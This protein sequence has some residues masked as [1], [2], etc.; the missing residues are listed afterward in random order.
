MDLE[1]IFLEEDDRVEPYEIDKI[2]QK[3]YIDLITMLAG[4]K[5]KGILDYEY[6]MPDQNYAYHT[7][8]VIWKADKDDFVSVKKETMSE[9][10]TLFRDME[11]FAFAEEEWNTW[12]F[13][14]SIYK[15]KR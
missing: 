2:M 7:I 15:E 13:M 5:A 1:N 12:Q 3:K 4:L 11:S 8:Y 10:L 9:I 14:C 6:T